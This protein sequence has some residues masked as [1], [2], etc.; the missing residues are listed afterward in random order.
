VAIFYHFEKISLYFR[1]GLPAAIEFGKMKFYQFADSVGE[2]FFNLRQRIVGAFEIMLNRIVGVYRG[3]ISAINNI[4]G[5]D[6]ELPEFIELSQGQE[7]AKKFGAEIKA[8]ADDVVF[9]TNKLNDGLA[10]LEDAGEAASGLSDGLEEIV[11][12][13]KKMETNADWQKFITGM[14][15]DVNS[16]IQTLEEAETPFYNMRKQFELLADARMLGIIKTDADL[17]KLFKRLSDFHNAKI[18]ED[19]REGWETMYQAAVYDA[20]PGQQLRDQMELLER[21]RVEL[22]LTADQYALVATHIA[23]TWAEANQATKG[24]ITIIEEIQASAAS[25]GREFS[26][27]LVDGLEAGKIAFADFAKSIL[28]Q[29]IKIMTDRI[30]VQFFEMLF[31]TTGSVGGGGGGGGGGGIFT[32]AAPTPQLAMGGGAAP[33]LLSGFTSSPGS[34]RTGGLIGALPSRSSALSAVNRRPTVSVTVNNNAGAEVDVTA[35]QRGDKID[36][37]IMIEK[38][39]EKSLSSGGLDRSMQANYGISRRAY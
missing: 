30:F 1:Y 15:N 14:T 13:A 33:G 4:P 18:L 20:D 12:A 35:T 2:A 29:V 5:V 25:F 21:M 6:L 16:L 34:S 38:Q 11:V 39:V 23:N 9:F 27:T 22:G 26:D 28:K 31:G 7:Y 3:V 32:F 24:A 17:A 10:A 8:A 19:L 36:L 37:E